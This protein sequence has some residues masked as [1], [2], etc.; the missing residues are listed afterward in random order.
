MRRHSAWND[1]GQVSQQIKLPP[2]KK[3]VS[4]RI[5]AIL[6]VKSFEPKQQQQRDSYLSNT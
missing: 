5:N 4:L 3:N 1:A 2:A 6:T